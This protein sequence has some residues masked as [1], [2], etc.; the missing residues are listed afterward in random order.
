MATTSRKCSG[1]ARYLLVYLTCGLIGTVAQVAVEPDSLIPILGASG[2]IA[3]VMGMYVIWFPH[4]RV[5]VLVFRFIA[6]MPALV[7]IG[8][9]IV[10]QVWR[11]TAH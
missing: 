5:R 9:W 7:V 1:T 2:A 8:L 10:M 11:D 3:G 6:E 4:N